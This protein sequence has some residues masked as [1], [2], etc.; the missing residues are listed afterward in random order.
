MPTIS[1][2][3]AIIKLTKSRHV[4]P[5]KTFTNGFKV[6]GISEN[7]VG[8]ICDE[9]GDLLS[10][11][12]DIDEET[13]QTLTADLDVLKK[14][15]VIKSISTSRSTNLLTLIVTLLLTT[16]GRLSNQQILADFNDD[17]VEVSDNED[18]ENEEG[19]PVT[20]P[21]LKKQEKLLKLLQ[22]L[23]IFQNLKNQ[24]SDDKILK[25]SKL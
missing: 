4:L 3:S 25:R 2:L 6:A 19:E 7:E 15:L 14:N 16:H 11:L 10:S 1:I 13:V 22:V 17:W 8:R 5:N 12:D 24:W 23:A 18:H 9:E 20:K 21:E